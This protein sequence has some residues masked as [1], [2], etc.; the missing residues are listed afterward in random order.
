MEGKPIPPSVEWK[1]GPAEPGPRVYTVTERPLHV[2]TAEALGWTNLMYSRE[3]LGAG[4]MGWVGRPPKGWLHGMVGVSVG[5]KP[6]MRV[7]RYDRDWSATGPLI[8][9]RAISIDPFR[10]GSDTHWRAMAWYGPTIQ[11]EDGTLALPW[12]VGP[13]ALLAVC[14]LLT[15]EIHAHPDPVRP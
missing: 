2:R 12:G 6:V 11:R 4:I 13:T 15:K 10:A 7:S 8:E 5:G 14:D 9:E 1:D 3:P